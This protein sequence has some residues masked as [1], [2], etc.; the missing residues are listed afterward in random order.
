MNSKQRK[1]LQAVFQNPIRADIRW[2][3]IESMLAA[4]GAVI[5]E[6]EGSRVMFMLNGIAAVFHRPHPQKETDRGAVKS[7]RRFLSEAGIKP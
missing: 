6:S 2:N 1:V 7:L 4:L 5:E 3:D